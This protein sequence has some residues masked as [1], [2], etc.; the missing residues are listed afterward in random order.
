MLLATFSARVLVLAAYLLAAILPVS[1]AN[2]GLPQ[3][4]AQ[5]AQMMAMA[6]HA[7]QMDSAKPGSKD[8]RL[9]L[10]QQ[11]C[12]LA[13]AT[14]PGLVRAAENSFVTSE[15]VLAADWLEATL[16]TPPPAPPPRAAVI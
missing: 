15:V 4:V 7:M 13:T 3:T 5:H 12:L 9:L 10:C 14:L 1:A 16:A 8:P 6:G 2:S 11:H